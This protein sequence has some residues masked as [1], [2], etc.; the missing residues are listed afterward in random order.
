MDFDYDRDYKRG[1]TSGS[2]G[3]DVLDRA[4]ADGRSKIRGWMD[5][6]L[7]AATG[8]AKWHLRD[9]KGCPEHSRL[10]KIIPENSGVVNV[11]IEH[12]MSDSE[13]LHLWLCENDPG[14][15]YT[16]TFLAPGLTYPHER[17]S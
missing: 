11:L 16:V 5:G 6:Y 10:M 1:W 7:D 15:I 9:C 4:D 17:V 13:A 3:S 2:R 14:E 8:R 12:G